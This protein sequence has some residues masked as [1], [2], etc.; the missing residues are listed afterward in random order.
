MLGHNGSQYL[1]PQSYLSFLILGDQITSREEGA[2]ASKKKKK[3]EEKIN[4]NTNRKW[5]GHVIYL[6]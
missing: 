4:K 2:K 1:L 5:Y 3:K 6:E